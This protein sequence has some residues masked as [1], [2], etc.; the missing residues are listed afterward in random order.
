MCGSVCQGT[1]SVTF[2]SGQDEDTK[3]FDC[4]QCLLKVL[5]CRPSSKSL[6]SLKLASWPCTARGHLVAMLFDSHMHF[7]P[8]FLPVLFH[9]HRQPGASFAVWR[10][11]SVLRI[12]G[13][14]LLQ[15]KH[16]S[17]LSCRDCSSSSFPDA[18]ARGGSPGSSLTWRWPF[19]VSLF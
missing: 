10:V 19:N 14:T 6:G 15:A 9:E 3:G 12:S 17:R 18:L 16:G 2:A 13:H 5:I 4:E 7:F 8:Q 11:A 1:P